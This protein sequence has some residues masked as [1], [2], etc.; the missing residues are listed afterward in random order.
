MSETARNK[1]G[2]PLKPVGNRDVTELGISVFSGN[3]Q[4]GMGIST[5]ERNLP[6]PPISP[7]VLNILERKVPTLAV[8]FGEKLL[9]KGGLSHPE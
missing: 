2:N 8:L 3:Y 6:T 7:M 1:T 9:E 5:P 4:P